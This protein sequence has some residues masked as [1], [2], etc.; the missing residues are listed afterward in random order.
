M[1]I[2][3]YSDGSK[4]IDFKTIWNEAILK[5]GH[6]TIIVTGKTGVGKSTL[7]NAVFS[8]DV[9]ETGVGRPITQQINEYSLEHFPI[10]IIDTKG[11]ELDGFKSTKDELI[12]EITRRSKDP[13]PSKHINVCWYCIFDGLN[14]IE[15]AEI[16]CLKELS[17]FVRVIVVL[18]QS[19][20]SDSTLY[21]T[22]KNDPELFQAD[23]KIVKVVALEKANFKP[24]G[25]DKLVEIT[26]SLLPETQ[27]SA[28]TAA[29]KIRID[30]KAKKA[31]IIVGGAATT[32]GTIG[33]VPIPFADALALIPI[34]VGMLAG[35]SATMGLDFSDGFLKTLI[36]S[37]IGTT[38]A[39][40]SGKA[41]VTGLIKL[42]PI[43]GQIVGG[44]ISGAT[45][46]TLTTALGEAYIKV[47]EKMLSNN[48]EI[49]PEKISEALREEWGE[50]KQ[51]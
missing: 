30:L 38:A 48:S 51:K 8:K 22:I 6:S 26:E 43:G 44:L 21:D 25:L 39:T 5:L 10:S 24:Y 31:H 47:L 7:I 20:F 4:T 13:D 11:L 29:Q 3:D 12:E 15:P 33:A 2:Q 18:T 36:A 42:I 45:A 41:I 37:T 1:N 17:K 19:Y 23:I 34:Q 16:D 32:A 40:L 35:I 50:N 14:R 46:A 28:F 49:T 27:K 9:A